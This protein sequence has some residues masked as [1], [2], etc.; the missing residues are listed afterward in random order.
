[1]FTAFK[2]NEITAEKGYRSLVVRCL[3]SIKCVVNSPTISWVIIAHFYSSILLFRPKIRWVG[4]G[5]TIKLHTLI[6]LRAMDNFK[7]DGVFTRIS[8]A[9]VIMSKSQTLWICS[10]YWSSHVYTG[11]DGRLPVLAIVQY[12]LALNSETF[13]GTH[14]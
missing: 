12:S 3:N 8:K 13:G 4:Q 10:K 14:V 1:M 5:K 2:S 7:I 6:S 9:F 11:F